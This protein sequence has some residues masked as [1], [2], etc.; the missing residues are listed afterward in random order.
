MAEQPDLFDLNDSKTIGLFKDKTP[1]NVIT[2]SYHIQAKSYYYGLADKSTKSK[3]KGVSKKGI[4]KMATN[5]YMPAL[6][7]SLLDDPI[8]RSLLSEQEANSL[9]MRTKADPMTLVYQDCLFGKEVFYAKNIG[10]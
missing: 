4:N 9:A 5:L 2:E 10:I 6:E 7:G 8:D 1:D 3:H